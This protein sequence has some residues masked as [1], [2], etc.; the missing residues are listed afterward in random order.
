MTSSEFRE[1]LNN[2]ANLDVE[3]ACGA[4]ASMAIGELIFV[5]GVN[6]R[7]YKNW[8]FLSFS[9]N[10]VHKLSILEVTC[11]VKAI[12]NE[13]GSNVFRV[14]FGHHRTACKFFSEYVG[15]ASFSSQKVEL[16]PRL[17]EGAGGTL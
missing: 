11:R 4:P 12:C 13:R 10:A 5:T 16:K 1:L 8:D 14:E 9:A 6:G 2:G 17:S 3:V 7:P 15:L